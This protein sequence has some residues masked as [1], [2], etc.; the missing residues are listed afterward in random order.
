[1]GILNTYENSY[2][3]RTCVVVSH[4][5]FQELLDKERELLLLNRLVARDQANT[6]WPDPS[7]TTIIHNGKQY[8]QLNHKGFSYYRKA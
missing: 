2:D 8:E 5:R 4:E 1:M 3:V 7:I 6:P